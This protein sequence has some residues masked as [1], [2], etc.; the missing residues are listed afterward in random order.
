MQKKRPTSTQMSH[1]PSQF[2]LLSLDLLSFRVRRTKRVCI[3]PFL[4]M[5]SSLEYCLFLILLHDH[6][7][8]QTSL[9]FVSHSSLVF[10][11]LLMVFR[12]LDLVRS[13]FFS[14]NNIYAFSLCSLYQC[15]KWCHY[16]LIRYNY[17]RTIVTN[18]LKKTVEH[19][20][21]KK[22]ERLIY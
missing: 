6:L 14:N 10:L 11:D 3:R 5:S 16:R 21:T 8:L 13:S 15:Q 4:L 18:S 1:Y 7:L 9:L 20:C 22:W 17:V 12:L 19:A 2:L